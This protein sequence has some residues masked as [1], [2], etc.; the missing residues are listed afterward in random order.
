MGSRLVYRYIYIYLRSLK[1]ITRDIDIDIIRNNRLQSITHSTVELTYTYS[2]DIP[3]YLPTY[4][5]TQVSI[6]TT[7]PPFESLYIYIHTYKHTLTI[8]LNRLR[9]DR[10]ID[11]DCLK[12]EGY[13]ILHPWIS[14]PVYRYSRSRVSERI[15][16]D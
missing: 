15:G 7:P 9:R 10:G 6:Y 5:S 3:T 1:L 2:R 4:L 13:M 8:T 14:V 16:L 11:V 12:F